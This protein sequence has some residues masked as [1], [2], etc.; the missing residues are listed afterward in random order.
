MSGDPL[1]F[2][3]MGDSCDNMLCLLLPG[4]HV[5]CNQGVTFIW[6][7]MFR[8]LYAY[9]KAWGE[10]VPLSRG[11]IAILLNLRS[12]KSEEELLAV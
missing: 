1:Y 8:R 4:F 6:R 2:V 9:M 5:P 11:D 12:L 7:R 3:L 10:D